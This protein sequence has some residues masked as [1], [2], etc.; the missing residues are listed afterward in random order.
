[1][2]KQ[3][4]TKYRFVVYC[5]GGAL[6]R[7]Y[8]KAASTVTKASYD[9][10]LV[11]IYATWLNACLVRII[12][13][14][15]ATEKVIIDPTKRVNFKKV[16]VAAGWKPG[17]STDYDAVLLAKKLNCKRIINIT[18]VDYLYDKDPTKFKDAKPIKQISWNEFIELIKCEWK[19]GLSSP[20][21][22]L[23]AQKAKELKIKVII[24]G[25]DM[26]NFKTLLEGNKFKGTIIS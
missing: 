7:N 2:V 4:L 26:N 9:L 13:K 12:L 19:P 25:K 10:D 20:F 23:A 24:I 6:A 5:G 14:E 16:V 15:F 18:N 11:G 22:P 21:D 1:M 17:W 3:F 8:Q